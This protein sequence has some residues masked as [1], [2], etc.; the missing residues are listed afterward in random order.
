MTLEEIRQLA[1]WLKEH[2]LAGAEMSR[3]GVHA[4]PRPLLL[5]RLPSLRCRTQCCAPLAWGACC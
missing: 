5:R 2:H 3:P 1:L 4:V